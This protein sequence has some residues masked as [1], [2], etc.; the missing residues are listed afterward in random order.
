MKRRS[1]VKKT[2]AL[3]AVSPVL[4]STVLSCKKTTVSPSGTA[5]NTVPHIP[6]KNYIPPSAYSPANPGIRT[7]APD[8][9][10]NIPV[11]A[12]TRIID[13]YADKQSYLPGSDCT[14]YLSADASYN[15]QKIN[16]YD[17]RHNIAFSIPVTTIAKQQMQAD[18]PYQNGYGYAATVTIIVPNI[19]SGV[20]LIAN[21]IPL[22][23]NSN[24]T[25][26]DFTIVYP[27]NT[28]NA[29]CLSGGKDLYGTSPAQ[30]IS[31]L[32]PIGLT[33]YAAGIFKW[34]LQQSY[35]YNVISDA[36]MDNMGSIKGKL[37][38]IAGHSEYWTKT[39]RQNFDT[40][41]S[42]GNPALV[43]SG[44][45]MYWHVKYNE[46]GDQLICYK[47]QTKDPEANPLDKTTYW[48]L[49]S[50]QFPPMQSIGVDGSLGGYGIRSSK[51]FQGIKIA[52]PSMLLFNGLNL[53]KGDVIPC[54]S[55][56]LDAG[57]IAGYDPDGFPVL[58]N[59]ILGFYRYHLIGYDIAL[60]Y[61][62]PN[63]F[64]TATAVM[65]RRTPTSGAVI[66]M[67]TTNWCTIP[68]FVDPKQNQFIPTIT[69]NAIDGLLNDQFMV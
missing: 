56:E 65:F 63:K 58:D 26:V 33:S 31:F 32:R 34:L 52:D 68:Y 21:S 8:E 39:A 28:E 54:S 66:N 53:K 6:P 13:G 59:S 5:N 64:N 49:P 48:Y 46:T 27:T 12:N 62:T 1:F 42:S 69:K 18:M 10:T 35:T 22:I 43:L 41:V 7:L 14:L 36:D 23:I 37:L 15:D 60:D 29:Y 11:L 17:L 4:A 40:H 2:G 55:H 24:T 25:N 20:Y 38:I 61:F 16:V 3:L 51:S 44:N 50:Q 9:G 45:S 47:D 30:I 19:P 67:A 57:P